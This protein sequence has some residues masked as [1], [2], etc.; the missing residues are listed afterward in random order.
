V[1][2]FVT[3]DV[4]IKAQSSDDARRIIMDFESKGENCFVV[5]EADALFLTVCMNRSY[6]VIVYG[7]YTGP[8]TMLSASLSACE[9]AERVVFD[10]S[11]TPTPIPRNMCLQKE[12]GIHVIIDFCWGQQLSGLV[13]WIKD[14]PPT[15]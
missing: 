5:E 9:I 12:L 15:K 13:H 1:C 2:S 3:N 8:R 10:V 4:R 7:D 11:G 14:S 6:M